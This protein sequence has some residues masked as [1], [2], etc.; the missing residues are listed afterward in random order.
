MITD[1]HLLTSIRNFQRIVEVGEE[2]VKLLEKKLLKTF[3]KGPVKVLK[4]AHFIVIE[5]IFR[6]CVVTV[7]NLLS[8]MLK[9][10]L[11]VELAWK[12]FEIQEKHLSKALNKTILKVYDS[13]FVSHDNVLPEFGL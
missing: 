11:I 9:F 5:L 4:E 13:S 3:E 7:A 10:Q 6:V 2:I 12:V 8:S 1:A